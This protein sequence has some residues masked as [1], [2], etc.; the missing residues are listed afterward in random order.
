[1]ANSTAPDT[2]SV[3]ALCRFP[4]KSMMGE[5]IN[6]AAVDHAGLVGDRAYA[7]VDEENGRVV[8]AKNPTRW[9]DFFSYRASYAAPVTT[10]S[11]LPPVWI[12]L[13][14][15]CLVRS[16][17]PGAVSTLSRALPVRIAIRRRP[18]EDSHLEQYW[19]E[20]DQPG[21]SS[22]EPVVTREQ[23]AADAPVGTFFDYAVVHLLTTAT[24][25]QLQ[26][27]HPQGRIE[28]R[29]FR[30]NIVV[31]TPA[32]ETGFVENGWVGRTIQI[33]NEVALKVTDPC[34]RCVMPTLAQ[35]DLPKDA[36]LMK[37][38]AQNN[39]YVPFAGKPLPCVGV[40]AKVLQGGVIRRGDQVSVH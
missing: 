22:G 15:G 6:S 18:P 29:R 35:G 16:D 20:R 7:L 4:V 38:I 1:M 5:E 28:A 40:Y 3:V 14:D 9:P 17:D 24:L 34:P 39:T 30:P 23:L 33:G 27:L 32:G 25:E 12:Q 26:R 13:P 21:G 8:S 19:P 36:A 37:V 2:Q 11:V 10:R 31:R